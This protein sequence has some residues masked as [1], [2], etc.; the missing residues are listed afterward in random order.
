MPL[1]TPHRH[2]DGE[3]RNLQYRL[4]LTWR[5]IFDTPFASTGLCAIIWDGGRKRL[6]YPLGID[7]DLDTGTLLLQQHDRARIATA[8]AT[9]QRFGHL[10]ERKVAQPHGQ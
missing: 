3:F 1:Q 10:G 4:R 5:S 7:S 8:P 2:G 6:A 9:R